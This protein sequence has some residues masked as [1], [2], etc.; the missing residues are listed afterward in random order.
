MSYFAALRQLYRALRGNP[1]G[2]GQRLKLVVWLLSLGLDMCIYDNL[3]LQQFHLLTGWDHVLV[4]DKVSNIIS[5]SYRSLHSRVNESRRG[6]SSIILSWLDTGV[7]NGAMLVSSNLGSAGSSLDSEVFNIFISAGVFKL[8]RTLSLISVPWRR[9]RKTHF[10]EHA[11]WIQFE[12]QCFYHILVASVKLCRYSDMVCQMR[13]LMHPQH[14]I[15]STNK[16]VRAGTR[17][18]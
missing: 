6:V 15:S 8:L 17:P 5:L 14:F 12:K 9:C 4:S 1:H 11:V 7:S 18:S 13:T 2:G 10:T 3:L 16:C